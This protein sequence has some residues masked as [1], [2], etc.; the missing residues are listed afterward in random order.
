MISNKKE[1]VKKL[2]LI[3]NI[4]RKTDFIFSLVRSLSPKLRKKKHEVIIEHPSPHP[5]CYSHTF[6]SEKG[7]NVQ[8]YITIV[9]GKL[10]NKT[11]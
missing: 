1:Q 2:D 11:A 7:G 5:R 10:V 8:I 4:M 3:R 6:S 9:L